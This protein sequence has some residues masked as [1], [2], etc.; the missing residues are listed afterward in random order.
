MERR[1]QKRKPQSGRTARSFYWLDD[2]ISAETVIE[3]TRVAEHFMEKTETCGKGRLKQT[4]LWVCPGCEPQVA[5]KWMAA[6]ESEKEV[7]EHE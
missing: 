7:S 5:G 4:V 3:C 1:R 6:L 2:S